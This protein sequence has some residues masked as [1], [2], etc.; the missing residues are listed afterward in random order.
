[1]NNL[2]SIK[3]SIFFP[4]LCLTTFGVTDI[5]VIVTSICFLVWSDLGPFHN[6]HYI[7]F[8]GG[9]VLLWLHF[10]SITKLVDKPK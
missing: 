5:I 7:V 4:A 10:V 3:S 9:P 8:I 2:P 1:M 6:M